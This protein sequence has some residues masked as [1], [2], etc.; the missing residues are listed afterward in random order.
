MLIWLLPAGGS[1][2]VY[3]ALRQ[4]DDVSSPT[5]DDVSSPTP[6]GEALYDMPVHPVDLPPGE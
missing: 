3:A 4:H 5:P 1:A 6:N 2:V